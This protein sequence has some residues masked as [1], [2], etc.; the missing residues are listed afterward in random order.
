M[1]TTDICKTKPNETKARFRSPFTPS[2]QEMDPANST[3]DG[4]TR[5]RGA[6]AIIGNSLFTI[7]THSLKHK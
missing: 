3:A 4:S 1:N 2:N 7:H 5:G 6:Q